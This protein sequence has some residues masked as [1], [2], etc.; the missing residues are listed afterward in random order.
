ME[1]EVPRTKHDISNSLQ[2]ILIFDTTSD[3]QPCK[4]CSV[5]HTVGETKC[6]YQATIV[7]KSVRINQRI[8]CL[9]P[10]HDKV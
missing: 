7:Q 4:Y 3:K 6:V 2:F 1:S 5:T 8:I 9:K 10:V